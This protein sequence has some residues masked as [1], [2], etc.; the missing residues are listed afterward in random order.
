MNIKEQKFYGYNHIEGF[1]KVIKYIKERTNYKYE[2]GELKTLQYP[3]ITF[4]GTVKLHGTNSSIILTKNNNYQIQSRNRILSLEHDNA[5]FFLFCN[6]EKR[7]EFLLEYLKNKFNEFQNKTKKTIEAIGIYGEYIGK[8]I[9]KGVGVS[10][11]E[12]TFAPFELR[13]FYENEENPEKTDVNLPLKKELNIYPITETKIYN[14]DITFT[15]EGINIAKNKIE[16]MLKEVENNCPYTKSISGKENTIGE[17]IVFKN[18]NFLPNNQA[19]MF[20]IKGDEHKVT[21]TKEKI[22]TE[23]DTTTFNEFINNTVTKNRLNQGIEYLKENEKQISIESTGE[24]IKW[25]LNDILREE[26]DTIIKNNL[27]IKILKKELSKK[28]S[29][30]YK[31]IIEV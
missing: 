31:K 4:K 1:E 6:Q 13:I 20:K 18:F 29:I 5:G 25:C 26:K 22:Q 3:T 8:G 24:F 30:E 23:I 2:I 27:N 21:K 12:K 17:G 16:E 10:E 14:I 7:K 11:L 9:Q 19:I 15:T 28:I